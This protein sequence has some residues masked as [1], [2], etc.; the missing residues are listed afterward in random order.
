MNRHERRKQ[1]KCGYSIKY[2]SPHR[3]IKKGYHKGSF[4]RPGHSSA[5]TMHS[6]T[7][8]ASAAAKERNS[9]P[10]IAG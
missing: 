7:P 10:V 6:N 4:G 5:V 1:E 2:K 8:P 9:D 3:G